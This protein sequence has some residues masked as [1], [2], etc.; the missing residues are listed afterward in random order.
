MGLK[1]FTINVTDLEEPCEDIF[2]GFGPCARSSDGKVYPQFISEDLSFKFKYEYDL[3]ALPKGSNNLVSFSM[4]G[5]NQ[6]G[7]N[8]PRV[9]E[10]EFGY[11]WQIKQY[12]ELLKEAECFAFPERDLFFYTDVGFA[13]FFQ[14]VDFIINNQVVD[15]IQ[16][17]DNYV[18]QAVNNIKNLFSNGLARTM[19][20]QLIDS[21]TIKLMPVY[22]KLLCATQGFI[23]QVL[24]DFQL[25][26]EDLKNKLDAFAQLPQINFDLT[27]LF[28]SDLFNEITQF[29]EAFGIT[30]DSTMID[31]GWPDQIFANKLWFD[32]VHPSAHTHR[33]I[34]NFV[35]TW[36]QQKICQIKCDVCRGKHYDWKC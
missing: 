27:V 7:N 33:V 36:F 19:Y 10:G 9:P 1:P 23:D 28:S 21:A 12:L 13:D 24:D 32:D 4:A 29:P 14:L 20:V 15:I 22:E 3:C 35:E 26:Q 30:N 5:S 18:T 16:Y 2:T 25:A 31:L 34:A 17:F 8:L 11:N 6:S